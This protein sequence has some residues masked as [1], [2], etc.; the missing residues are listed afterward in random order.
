MNKILILMTVTT[1]TLYAQM[2]NVSTTP[3]LRTALSNAATNGE[4]DTIT[5]ADGIYKTTDD[6][7]GTFIYFSN[8]ANELT[9][10]GSSSE[11]VILSGDNQEQI[12]N[13]QSTESAPMKLEKLS[14]VDGNNTHDSGGGVYTDYLIEI[15]NCTFNNNYAS[16]NGGGLYS[17]YADFQSTYANKTQNSVVIFASIFSNNTSRSNGGGFYSVGGAS[18]TDSIFS[19]NTSNGSGGG[20]YSCYDAWYDIAL[21]TNSTFSDNQ[22]SG[23]GGGFYS[24]YS[25]RII[26]SKLIHNS[27]K[28]NGGGFYSYNGPTI[29]GSTLTSNISE[30]NGGGFYTYGNYSISRLSISIV[31]NNNAVKGGAFYVEKWL[32]VINILVSSNSSGLYIGRYTDDSINN[33]IYNSI[34]TNNNGLDIDAVPNIIISHLDYNYIDITKVNVTNFESNNIFDNVTLGFVDIDN[35]D[36]K[37]TASSDL[38]D[39]G[40][41]DIIEDINEITLPE[42]D[43]DGN[44]RVVG[45]GIDIGPYEF[46]TTKPTLNSFTYTGIAKELNQLTFNVDYTLDGIRTLDNITYDYGNDGSWTADNTHAFDTAGMYTVNVKVTDSEG[47]YSTKPLLVTI[48]EISLTDKLLTVITQSDI[49]DILPMITADKDTAVATAITT[50]T[51]AGDAAGRDYVQ[52]NPAEFALVTQAASDLAV[53]D[54]TTTATATGVA[55]GKQYVQDNVAEFGLVTK[56][57]IELTTTNISALSTGWTLV[58][59]PFVITD[60]SVFDSATVVWVYNN[61]TSTWSAYSSNATTRQKIIDN[62]AVTLITTIPAGSGVW[63]QKQ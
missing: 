62:A 39:A 15:N 51:V 22:S 46:S 6:G 12:L 35:N 48:V 3:E 19:N 55:S 52:T 50:A 44:I 36:Y 14:F 41:T 28:N 56:S 45:G 33:T 54:A 25:T 37:L 40:T 59:T 57:D 34:F 58:S 43:L 20:F 32:Q 26:N 23:Y 11:N 60:L 1:L 4:D 29:I 63:I 9:L 53:S 49:D 27:A 8:E 31:N 18:V 16:S 10:V 2:F 38:I 24:Q 61:S 5:L 42:A 21:I 30:G 7:Q 13:H 17:K 47:E